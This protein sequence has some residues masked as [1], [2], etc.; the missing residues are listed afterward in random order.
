M[1]ADAWIELLQLTQHPEGGYYREVYR[2]ENAIPQESLSGLYDGAR[3][4]STCIYFLLKAGEPSKFHRLA[5]DELWHFYAGDPVT[6]HLI[7]EKG[8]HQKKLL[9]P[10]YTQGQAFIQIIPRNS[11][12]GAAV[13]TDTAE[14]P[15]RFVLIG[16]TVAPGFDF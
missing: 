15:N 7:D 16:C 12:F 13:S 9:G 10:D 2:S 1:T 3:V 4:Y 14:A 8:E 6:I 11:W 5:S